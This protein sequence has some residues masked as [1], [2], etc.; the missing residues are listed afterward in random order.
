MSKLSIYD[1][2]ML[3]WIDESGCDRRNS[4]RKY[5]YS[6]RGLRPVDHTILIRGIRYSTIPVMS[7]NAIHDV[8]VA[9]GTING[10]RFSYFI[11]KCLL[12]PLKPFNYVNEMSVVNMDSA[13]IHH[14]EHNIDLIE[15]MGAKIIF[16]PPYSPDLNPLEPVF[17]KIEAIL[18]DN[19]SLFQTTLSCSALI[20]MA[21]SM[22]T[23]QDCCNFVSHCGYVQ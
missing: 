2:S 4:F 8:L 5:G 22:I 23:K 11:E 15:Q 14:T 18:K 12:P 13:S 20:T 6:I 7:M 1:P 21:F 9:A 19:N 10:E 3:V 16:L 17:G